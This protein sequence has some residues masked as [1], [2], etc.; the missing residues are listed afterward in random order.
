MAIQ[1]SGTYYERDLLDAI[2]GRHLQG[3][4][5]D[6]GAHYGNHTVYFALECGAQRL[7]GQYC[8]TPTWLGMPAEVTGQ[9]APS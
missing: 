8:W 3:T 5:V 6:V 7:I 4:F 9:H 1:E 2:R